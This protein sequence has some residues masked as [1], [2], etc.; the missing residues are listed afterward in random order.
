M[1]NL[2]R[3]TRWLWLLLA[4][5]FAVC[6][7]Y[8]LARPD[9]VHVFPWAQPLNSRLRFD[10]VNLD[11]VVLGAPLLL[12][13]S[14]LFAWGGRPIAPKTSAMN[15]TRPLPLVE[16][17]NKDRRGF[18]L[19]GGTLLLLGGMTVL[20]LDRNAGWLPVLLWGVALLLLAYFWWR[21][22]RQTAVDLS[23]QLDKIDGFWLL[24]LLLLGLIIGTAFLDD[25]PA[26]LIGDEGSFW[27][28]SRAIASGE[29]RP[30]FFDLGVYTFPMA[31]TYGQAAV[32]WLT[33]QTIWSWRFASVLAGLLAILPLYGLAKDWFGRGTAVLAAFVLITSPYFLAFAR[34]GY[35]N[36]QALLPVTLTVYFCSL[37]IQRG[38]RFY[39]WLAGMAAGLGFYTYTAGR[40]GLVLLLLTMLLLLA[41]R[42]VTVRSLL[43]FGLLLGGGWLVMVW[44]YWLYSVNGPPDI[45]PYKLWESLFFNVFYGRSLFTDVELFRYADPIQIGHQ[46]LFFQPFVYGKL[47]LRGLVR[48]LLVFN[49][50]FFGGEEHFIETG[51]AGGLLPGI[52][53]AF[54]LAWSVRE[55]RRWPFAWLLL[56]FSSAVLLLSVTNTVPPR[57]THM[58]VVIPAL[59]L[60]IAAAMWA[61]VKTFAV[62]LGSWFKGIHVRR[63]QWGLLALGVIGL[64]WGAY[65]HYFW[66]L[67]Q[68]YPANFEQ[69]VAWTA[70]RLPSDPAV[71]LL[72]LETTPQHHDVAY[73]FWSNMLPL[74]YENLALAPILSGQTT[75]LNRKNLLVFVPASEDP[76]AVEQIA[77]AIPGSLPVVQF[78]GPHGAVMGYA[79]GNIAVPS[80][81]QL[82]PGGAAQSILHS[83]AGTPILAGSI[84]FALFGLFLLRRG[85]F[86]A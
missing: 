26:R 61:G 83:T 43:R 5:V 72:Y 7:Q 34:V 79:V 15:E 55:W 54:G 32:L 10:L 1:N 66:P 38:S 14:L 64:A 2:R 53:L 45:A 28:A 69:V 65:R 25:I 68:K 46:T 3:D 11:N 36:S 85:L 56:W 48:S 75:P 33:G 30:S 6:G 77:R 13:G 59:A 8:L 35:N 23:L 29:H 52:C 42:Q 50:P 74:S 12:L 60:F 84:F 19:V 20:L 17:V 70:V 81:P 78:D 57:A 24:G 63:W 73:M 51:L 16:L 37:A 18:G 49:G 21:Q 82:S 80:A 39:F 4:V 22:D 40:L 31:S 67:A 58:V 71:T 86:A 44:P 76:T 47:L 27:E 41:R 62:S 9:A